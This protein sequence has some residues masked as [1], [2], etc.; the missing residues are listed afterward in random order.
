MALEGEYNINNEKIIQA[1]WIID[2][3]SNNLSLQEHIL[4]YK[5]KAPKNSLSKID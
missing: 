4:L 3:V 1:L 2:K 5:S